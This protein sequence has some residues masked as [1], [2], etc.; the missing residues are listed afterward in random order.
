MARWNTSAPLGSILLVV[1]LLAQAPASQTARDDEFE[2]RLES[3]A[4]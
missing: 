3:A 4:L 1:G 2:R